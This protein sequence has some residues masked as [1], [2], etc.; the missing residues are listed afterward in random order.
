MSSLYYEFNILSLDGDTVTIEA[1]TAAQV[2][3]KITPYHLHGILNEKGCNL[4]WM[5]FDVGR[6]KF[7]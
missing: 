1:L 2:T 4:P 5:L 7:R 3:H 6:S